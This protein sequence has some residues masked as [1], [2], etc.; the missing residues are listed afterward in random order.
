[1]GNT[2]IAVAEQ[3]KWITSKECCLNYQTIQTKISTWRGVQLFASTCKIILFLSK[4]RGITHNE[5]TYK[6][7]ANEQT[8]IG[9][10]R[11]TPNTMGFV[12]ELSAEQKQ[13]MRYQRL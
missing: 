13:K 1:M 10:L 12:T 2:L 3:G 11:A 4:C 9:I 8:T 5:F 7:S 6:V